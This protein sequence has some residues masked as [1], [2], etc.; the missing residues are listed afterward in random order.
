MSHL[1]VLRS[2]FKVILP[3][4]LSQLFHTRHYQVLKLSHSLLCQLFS[5]WTEFQMLLLYMPT[6]HADSPLGQSLRTALLPRRCSTYTDAD[7]TCYSDNTLSITQIIVIVVC[8]FAG[9]ILLAS[10][11][12]CIALFHNFLTSTPLPQIHQH[13]AEPPALSRTD[14]LDPPPAYTGRRV[15]TGSL[16]LDV[17][18]RR[19]IEQVP[20]YTARPPDV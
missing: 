4:A 6:R 10:F 2:T 3:R 20:A 16:A 9:L 19:T 13:A 7:Q 15:N 17:L 1:A 14:V 11:F 12:K 18:P 5:N 8:V